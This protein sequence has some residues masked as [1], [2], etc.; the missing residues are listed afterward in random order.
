MISTDRVG[1]TVG[2]FLTRV[3]DAGVVQL[4]QQTCAAMRTFAEERSYTVMTG[5][6]VVAGGTGTVVNVLTAVI[7]SPPVHTNTLVA[8]V[9]V[10]ARAAILACIGHQLALVNILSAELTCEFWFTLAVV[11]IDSI[12]TSPSILAV[13]PRTVIY[14]LVAV[15][16]CETWHTGTFIAGLS[17]LDAGAS[18]M[19]GRRV[20][21]QVTALTVLAR[22]LCR[23][24]AP[25]AADLVDANTAILAG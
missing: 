2:A 22:V 25:V 4:A 9:G 17:F 3:A 11:G 18:I 21:G 5:G 14:V 13:M 24:L 1:V 6:S 12:D 8:A 23:A 19:T 15:F 20:A 10:V 16:S 7:P